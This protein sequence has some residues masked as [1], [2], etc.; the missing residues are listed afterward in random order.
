MGSSTHAPRDGSEASHEMLGRDQRQRSPIS[1]TSTVAH[2]NRRWPR[3]LLVHFL[4][5]A[6]LT[7]TKIGCDTSQCGACTGLMEGMAV[8]ACTTLAVQADGASVTTIEG[9]A[10]NGQLTVLQEA[11]GRRMVCSV[12]SARRAWCSPPTRSCAPI[13]IHRPRRSVTGSKETYDALD[14]I[15]VDY[16]PLPAVVDPQK[17][18]SGAP[19]L[20]KD[21][22]G[23]VAFHW[24]VAG[25]DVEAA[26]SSAGVVVRDRIIQQRL[27]PTAMETRGAVAPY[28]PATGELTLWNTTQNP[29]I[30]RFIMSVVTGVPRTSIDST[31][32]SD[33]SSGRA[34]PACARSAALLAGR[35]PACR[36]ASGV[37]DGRRGSPRKSRASAGRA[38]DTSR[39]RLERGRPLANEGLRGFHGRGAPACPRA[40]AEPLVATQP[41]PHAPVGACPRRSGGSTAGAARERDARRRS[42]RVAPAAPAQCRSTARAHRR[43]RRFDGAIRPRA[44]ALPLRR[45]AQRSPGG[46]VPVRDTVD[47]RDAAADRPA[48]KPGEYRATRRSSEHIGSRSPAPGRNPR[49]QATGD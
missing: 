27:I 18:A 29:H 40:A 8:K 37:G 45:G 12:A 24:T 49:R 43:R 2:I 26:V 9:L 33:S 35:A 15:D 42:R 25:G 47:P 13:P 11:S 32:R 46:S 44:G 36:R 22:P 4:R 10:D 5:D 48:R 30:V 20:H 7:G 21:I 41:A 16:E 19:Q 28:V 17:A 3:L 34:S 39:R 1:T 14:L 6:G 31:R 38:G 23:N